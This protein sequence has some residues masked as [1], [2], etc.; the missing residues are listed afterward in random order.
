QALRDPPARL[1]PGGGRGDAD[2]EA[3]PQSHPRALRG[4]DRAALRRRAG[5]AQN[6]LRAVVLGGVPAAHA[7]DAHHGAR[8]RRVDEPPAADVD[9]DVAETREE[10]EVTGLELAPRHG[11]GIRVVPLRDRV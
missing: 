1:L 5:L 2:A 9:P 3:A 8:V 7:V 4:R 11:Y 10:D 6:P